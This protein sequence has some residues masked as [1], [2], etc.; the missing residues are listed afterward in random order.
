MQPLSLHES[1]QKLGAR[2]GAVDGAEIVEDYG[3][4]PA[5]HVALTQTA[6]VIDLSSRSRLCLTG[7]DRVRFLHGQVT[8]DVKRLKTGEGCYA[9]LVSSKGR[10]Q[11]DVNIYCL[12]EEL[13]LDFEPGLT[14]R[15]IERLERYIIA[16]DVQAIDVNALYGLLSIQGPASAEVVKNLG[17]F[18]NP[19]IRIGDFAKT[20]DAS[21]GEVYVAKQPRLASDGYDFFLPISGLAVAADNFAAAT[22]RI[23]GRFCGWKAFEMSRIEAG[24]PRFGPDMDESNFPQE[25]GIESRA[26][27][28]NKGCY[29]GQEVLNRI[30]TMGHVNR[31]LRGMHLA[32]IKVLPNKGD[33]LFHQG[34]EVGIV[35]SAIHSL[36]W[37][38][39]IALGYARRE[40]AQPGTELT[41]RS[42]EEES[43]VRVVD[44]PFHFV[45]K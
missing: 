16:D 26:L 7:S 34:R 45:S 38:Q 28:Y 3:A 39:N 9:A 17:W 36:T 35:T 31:E 8:N 2:F 6:G 20:V 30:H 18:S 12:A 4:F 15:V 10:M 1:H 23:G 42:A 41:L 29:I 40:N 44:L 32:E 21:L 22:N 11:S 14:Q 25:C 13:L 37:K 24:I 43:P 5:E 33:K 19:P 27:S